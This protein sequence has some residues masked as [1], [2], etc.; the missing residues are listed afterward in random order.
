MAEA[1]SAIYDA[2]GNLLADAEA[3]LVDVPEGIVDGIDLDALG[4]KIYSGE[5]LV[6]SMTGGVNDRRVSPPSN[7]R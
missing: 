3:I 2:Q 7:H 4:W 1:S 5:E 6:E